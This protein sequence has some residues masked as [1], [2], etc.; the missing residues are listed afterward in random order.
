MSKTYV[1][2]L[3]GK[4]NFSKRKFKKCTSFE[5]QKVQG[6]FGETFFLEL[7]P[8]TVFLLQNRISE[9]KGSYQSSLEN[10]V[11]DFRDIMNFSQ[12]SWLKIKISKN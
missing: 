8:S 9:I 11:D 1:L 3:I 4:V 10:E 12:I 2:K 6:M 7:L 5:E